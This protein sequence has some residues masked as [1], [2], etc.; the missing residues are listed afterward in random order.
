M[1]SEA[2]GRPRK[3]TTPE[4][5]YISLEDVGYALFL[6][7]AAPVSP[8][9][10]ALTLLAA[11]ALLWRRSKQPHKDAVPLPPGPKRWPIIG[12]LLEMPRTFE[13]ETYREW[14]RQYGDCSFV[15]YG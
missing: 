10:L 2:S 8:L 1:H 6:E 13:H 9:L 4:N 12:G 15:L 11:V 3:L 5:R 14:S 7:M